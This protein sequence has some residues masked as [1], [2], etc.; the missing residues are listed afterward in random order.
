MGAAPALAL[1]AL[2][3]GRTPV[4]VLTGEEDAAP[5][6]ATVEDAA[7]P[8]PRPP[9]LAPPAPAPAM[10]DARPD[11]PPAPP[12]PTPRPPDAGPAVSCPLPGPALVLRPEVVEFGQ[13]M[14]G[15]R[16]RVAELTLTNPTAAEAYPV[17]IGI[18]GTG[19]YLGGSNCTTRLGPGA[20][21]RL[22]V[23]FHATGSGGSSEGAVSFSGATPCGPVSATTVLRA[24][25]PRVDAGRPDPPP[26]SRDAGP[27]PD[28][29]MGNARLVFDRSEHDFG[30][31]LLCEPKTTSF[32]LSNLG[33]GPSG[34]IRVA[35]ES[36]GSEFRIE[37]DG[38]S[39]RSLP[40]TGTCPISVTV[41]S[42]SQGSYRANLMAVAQGGGGA[43][44]ARLM[45]IV[46]PSDAAPVLSGQGDFGLVAV[47]KSSAPVTFT[48]TNPAFAGSALMAK[49]ALD[50]PAAAGFELL[51][52]DCVGQP[53]EPGQSCKMV[54]RF[55]PRAPGFRIASLA[56]SFAQ[57]FNCD[58][59]LHLQLSGTGI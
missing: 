36:P 38:C 43:V 47:G 41:E 53:L 35:L 31:V 37:R 12:P 45:A 50:D 51:Q 39:G 26:P 23:E 40:P 42:R 5:P 52:N 33:D 19:F 28:A 44:S 48:L 54:V 11:L 57:P 49:A 16:M 6:P 14:P 25:S 2:G 22:A 1:M 9:D 30:A 27:P 13:L 15:E 10:P 3:C 58:S 21:C 24:G 34:P 18:R 17:I 46:L 20:S 7:A 4:G 32:V 56:V 29:R 59:A 8:R 55:S